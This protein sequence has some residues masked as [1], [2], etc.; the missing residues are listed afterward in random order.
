MCCLERCIKY[1]ARAL[2]SLGTKVRLQKLHCL[3]QGGGLRAILQT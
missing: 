2:S 3:L 1:D